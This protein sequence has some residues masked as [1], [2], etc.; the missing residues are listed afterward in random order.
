MDI[1]EMHTRFITLKRQGQGAY[2]S[3]EEIDRFLNDA[4]IDKFN[5]E[6][7]LFELNGYISDNLHNFKTSAGITFTAGFSLLPGDYGYRTN[8]STIVNPPAIPQKVE[9]VPEGEWIERIN[10]PIS[11]PSE[12]NP[13]CAIR[14]QIEVYPITTAIMKLYYLKKPATMVFGYTEDGDGNT[15]YASGTSTQCDWP[16]EAQV[17]I[18]L[19]ALVYAGVSLP[20]QVMMQAKGLK[21]QTENV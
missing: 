7:R 2:H 11:V 10:D 20:D 14:D 6:K 15:I 8:A 5:E 4:S 17:D 1:N 13:I 18:I 19:R 12:T 9:I 3:R 16:P 21:K